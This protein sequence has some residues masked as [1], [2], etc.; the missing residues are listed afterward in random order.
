M[1]VLI[2]Y[3]RHS[4]YSML[5]RML[6]HAKPHVVALNREDIIRTKPCV[7]QTGYQAIRVY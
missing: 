5:T 1:T 4:S 6:K 7:H 2:W 3:Y